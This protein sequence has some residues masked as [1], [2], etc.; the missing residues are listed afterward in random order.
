MKTHHLV[1]S[2]FIMLFAIALLPACQKAP[3]DPAVEPISDME[4]EVWTE[5]TVVFVDLEGGF[6]GIEASDGAKYDP[7]YLDEAFQEDGLRVRFQYAAVDDAMSIR[8]W[9]RIVEILDIEKVE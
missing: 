4:V 9:G 5:G 2:L 6:Y 1:S 7:T 8:Q 3:D